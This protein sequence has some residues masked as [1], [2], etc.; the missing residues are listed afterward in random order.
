MMV[1][2]GF[3]WGFSRFF[4]GFGVFY[5]V[6]CFLGFR[7]WFFRGV[8]WGYFHGMKNF[9]LRKQEIFSTRPFVTLFYQIIWYLGPVKA[10]LP[11]DLSLFLFLPSAPEIP[12]NILPKKKAP[13]LQIHRT[14]NLH[15]K[16]VYN[17]TNLRWCED[18]QGPRCQTKEES[19]RQSLQFYEHMGVGIMDVHYHKSSDGQHFGMSHSSQVIK[20]QL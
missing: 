2:R 16:K 3:F 4:L 8:F 5:L 1:L 6:F 7:F 14:T 12:F 18:H 20:Q 9:I 10:G 15:S 11:G 17:E 19:V 13:T